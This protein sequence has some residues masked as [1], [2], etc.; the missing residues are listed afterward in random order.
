[1]RNDWLF[2]AVPLFIGVTFVAIIGYYAAVGIIAYRA[3]NGI[4]EYCKGLNAAECLGKSVSDYKKHAD[5][6]D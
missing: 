3:A 5:K 6:R 1:M 4:G 2:K